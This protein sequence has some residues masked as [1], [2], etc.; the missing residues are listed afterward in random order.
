[1]SAI[2]GISKRKVLANITKLKKA[3]LIERIGGTRG[4]WKI[5]GSND[6]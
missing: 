1:L 5:T 2:I 3:G 4:F 6:E